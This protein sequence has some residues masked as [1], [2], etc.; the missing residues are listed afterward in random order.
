MNHLNKEFQSHTENYILPFLWLKGENNETIRKEL[1]AIEACGIREI[2]LESRPHPDFCGSGWWKN[3]DFIFSEAESRGMRVWVLDDR[4]FPTGYANGAFIR[5]PE[6]AKWYL[7]ER[8][9]DVLG[10]CLDNA[11][12]VEPFLGEDGKLLGIIACPKPDGETTN[13]SGDEILDLTAQYHDG[14]LYFSLPPGPYRLFVFY[15]T[16]QHGGREHYMNLI[17]RH[18]VRLLIDEVYEKHYEHYAQFFGTVFAGFFSDEPELGNVPGYPFQL[19]LGSPD[20]RLPWSEELGEKLKTGWKER[21]LENLPALWYD[22]GEK[23]P[24]VRSTYMD[25]VTKLVS[26]CFSGQ[27]GDWCRAHGVEYIGHILEDDNVHARLG[28]GTGHYFREMQGQ[29]MAG[30]DVVH[31]QIVPGFTRP[32]HQWIAGDRDGEFFQFGLAKLASSAAHLDPK[33]KG[34]ALCELFG[35]YGWAEGVSF[36]KWLTDHMLVRGINHFTPHA[37]AMRYPDPDCPP[38]F[39]AQGNNPQFPAFVQLMKY[40]D[41]ACR[42]LSGGTHAAEAAV[43]Y[44][45]ES[46]WAGGTT[47]LFQKP[48]RELME[49]MMDGDVV[50]A[51]S[52]INAAAENGSLV[53]GGERYR[54]LILPAC[55]RFPSAVAKWIV[56]NGKSGLPVY[57]IETVPT[58]D[59]A[60]RALPEGFFRAVRTVPLGK[61]AEVLRHELN[62]ELSAFPENRYLRS[63]RVRQGKDLVCMFFNEDP[64]RRI[65]TVLRLGGK[66][67]AKALRLDLWEDREADVQINDNSLSLSL[68]PGESAFYRFAVEQESFSASECVAVPPVARDSRKLSNRWK[69]SRCA[70]GSTKWEQL[71]DLEPGCYPNLN[72]PNGDTRFAG[73]YRYE[74]VLNLPE[75]ETG[76]WLLR[77]PEASDMVQ[78]FL[79]G[80]DLGFLPQIPGEKDLTA[81]ARPGSNDLA[82]EIS[83][84]LVWRLRDGVSAFFQIR[85]TGLAQAPELVFERKID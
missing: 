64:Y 18:S 9:L 22:C 31:Y 59:T 13:V 29:D 72:G 10:P 67:Y 20:I 78:I 12:F 70:A 28:C 54:C 55:T 56:Q 62:P 35:N 81:A 32:I 51:D 37:F 24:E 69:L 52:I 68:E 50:P 15:S 16:Q 77:V 79:N 19:K 33:K 26:E 57:A 73:V 53:L 71:P 83:T 6:L 17:D 74:G 47:M 61:L 41:R 1:D 3:L 42:L 5:H 4:K 14:F 85:P 65:D 30:V 39:Y 21:F 34:R 36:M 75:T 23:T 8:H 2:C 84:T 25:E 45:A 46:E 48:L 58:E 76:R 27:V 43:L 11:A 66:Q 49:H 60:G 40:M 7:A 82:L 80:N 38:H 63:F 44:H